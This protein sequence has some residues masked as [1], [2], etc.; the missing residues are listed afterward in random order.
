M[1]KLLAFL[2]F[3]SVA[4]T[5]LQACAQ[6]KKPVSPHTS[7]S[8]TLSSGAHIKITYGAPSV[9]GRKIGDNLEPKAGQL[10]RAGADSA[11]T[12]ETSKDVTI[13][14]QALPA[15]KYAF[16]A[17]D[18]GDGSWTL[19]FNKTWATWGAYDYE[20]NKSEDALKVN[21]KPGKGAFT[22]K[23][24]YKIDKSGKVSLLWGD[25]NVAFNVK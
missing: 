2:M 17:L 8:Q 25:L 13:E 12:F 4:L 14:G 24:T 6:D 7:T 3:G 11:T 21:V 15:G 18:N 23:L 1:K 22:E 19:I 10:W 16:F 9:R 5:S 20:K